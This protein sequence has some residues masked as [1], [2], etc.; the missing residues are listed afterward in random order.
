[1]G[2]AVQPLFAFLYAF[3]KDYMAIPALANVLFDFFV[4]ELL[5][6]PRF[7][8]IEFWHQAPGCGSTDASGKRYCA[9]YGCELLGKCPPTGMC[10]WSPNTLLGICAYKNA[11]M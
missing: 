11:T 4:Q 6:A 10:A 9:L 5:T 2:A 1:M 3:T 7:Q 8:A